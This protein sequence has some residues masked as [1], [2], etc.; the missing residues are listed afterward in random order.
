MTADR[1][2]RVED[3]HELA[4]AMPHVT[5]V[6]GSGGNAVYQVGGKSFVFFRTPRPDA[7]DAEGRKLPDVIV[8]WVPDETDKLALVQDERTPFFTTSHFDGHRSV[9]VQASRLGEISRQ[10]LAE[11]VQDAWLAQASPRR[12]AV[13]LTEHGAAD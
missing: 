6:H 12:R 9:L 1:P 2:A 5:V 4:Q 13:W 11:V 7:V 3:V 8:F 10:E